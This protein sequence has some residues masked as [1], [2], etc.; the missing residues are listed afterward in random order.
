MQGK[1]LKKPRVCVD[2]DGVIAYHDITMGPYKFGKPLD[3]AKEF[4]LNLS[5]IATVV[6]YSARVNVDPYLADEIRE[7]MDLHGLY[8][9]EI[10]TGIGKSEAIAYVDDRSVECNPQDDSDA[11]CVALDKV[12]NNI[13]RFYDGGK[14]WSR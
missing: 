12:R 11:Y 8:Y 13:S 14:E 3:G 10:Y 2:F 5:E 1:H 4:L 9:D 7:Y 6:I